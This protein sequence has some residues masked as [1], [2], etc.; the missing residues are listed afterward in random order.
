M[1]P[2]LR[3]GGPGWTVTGLVER[4]VPRLVF[5]LKPLSFLSTPSKCS[6]L[7]YRYASPLQFA[8]AYG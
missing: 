1:L 6:L 8:G 3:G 7:L 2:V 4:A 5:T